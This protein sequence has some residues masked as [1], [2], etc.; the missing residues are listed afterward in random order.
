[1][2]SISFNRQLQKVTHTSHHC[3]ALQ[4]FGHYAQS[5]LHHHFCRQRSTPPLIHPSLLDLPLLLSFRFSQGILFESI[6]PV[7]HLFQG[8]YFN[9]VVG[10]GFL[11]ISC[12][13][14]LL[15]LSKYFMLQFTNLLI[16]IDCSLYIIPIWLQSQFVFIVNLFPAPGYQAHRFSNRRTRIFCWLLFAVLN[17]HFTA[18][19]GRFPL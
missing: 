4:V 7:S 10:I 1:M 8:R 6:V 2:K 11:Y 18:K 3:T 15:I 12:S 9:S 16:F 19:K 14:T 17:F 5:F 13:L